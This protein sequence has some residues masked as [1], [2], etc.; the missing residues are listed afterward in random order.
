MGG[1]I[2]NLAPRQSRT[3]AIGEGR[4]GRR[5]GEAEEW[6]RDGAA[7]CERR[8]AHTAPPSLL[9]SPLS[10]SPSS[11]L[12]FSVQSLTSVSTPSSENP[13][14]ESRPPGTSTAAELLFAEVPGAA[15]KPVPLSDRNAA[16]K[17]PPVHGLQPERKS[18]LDALAKRRRLRK[19]VGSLIEAVGPLVVPEEAEAVD[20]T[21]GEREE[22]KAARESAREEKVRQM[23]R[24]DL[25][26]M[27]GWAEVLKNLPS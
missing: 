16:D 4:E 24:Y 21:E 3:Y 15:D 8:V 2:P 5:G 9:I 25:Y 1:P 12:S 18:A 13:R 20:L 22:E 26:V 23:A 27:L 17:T 10:P 19:A 7:L 6:M 11:A 14:S